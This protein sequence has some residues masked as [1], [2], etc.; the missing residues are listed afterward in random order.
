VRLRHKF[1]AKPT[2]V[3]GTRYDSKLEA[4]YA[5][6]LAALK[7]AGKILG[8]LEQVPVKLPGTRYLVDFQV[9]DADG[10]VRFVEVKGVETPAWKA[11]M[12]AVA[13]LYPWLEIEIV[14]DERG[15]R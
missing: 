9:F 13:E 2:T 5:A 11:K 4:R 7:A 14:R 10:T 1:G 12:R 8:W 6:H 15:F 3:N